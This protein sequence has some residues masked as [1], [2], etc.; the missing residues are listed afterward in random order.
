VRSSNAANLGGIQV[1]RGV[2]ECDDRVRWKSRGAE[3]RISDTAQ[4]LAESCRSTVIQAGRLG[5]R[6]ALTVS[7]RCVARRWSI[8]GIELTVETGCLIAEEEFSARSRQ[9]DHDSIR[10]WRRRS[11]P[12]SERIRASSNNRHEYYYCHQSAFAHGLTVAQAMRQ[13]KLLS[14]LP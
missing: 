11:L 13:K 2:S 10:V 5:G 7:H 9:G 6:H 12:T 1:A 4:P 3:T 8:C 14:P